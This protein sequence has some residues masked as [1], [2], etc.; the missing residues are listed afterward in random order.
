MIHHPVTRKK[1]KLGIV[2]HRTSK[3]QTSEIQSTATPDIQY[4]RHVC[5]LWVLHKGKEGT[6]VIGWEV[7]VVYLDVSDTASSLM[8]GLGP[9]GIQDGLAWLHRVG[10]LACPEV[11]HPDGSTCCWLR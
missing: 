9:D 1:R 11:H 2:S 6:P 8:L 5:C 4:L 10:A 7:L 3:L